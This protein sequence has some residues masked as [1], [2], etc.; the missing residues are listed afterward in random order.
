MLTCLPSLTTRI[1]RGVR[2]LPT[3]GH[4]LPNESHH[5]F[6]RAS[7]ADSRRPHSYTGSGHVVQSESV[8]PPAQPRCSERWWTTR[9]ATSR[10]SATVHPPTTATPAASTVWLPG[11]AT[12]GAAPSDSTTTA[13]AGW[14]RGTAAQFYA[15]TTT[16]AVPEFCRRSA[17]HASAASTGYTTSS[18][19]T[20]TSGGTAGAAQHGG[21][22]TAVAVRAARTLAAPGPF[23]ERD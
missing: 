21:G 15:A 16:D 18:T 7:L 5:R 9:T 17:I 1:V 10:W 4:P 8:L 14:R 19:T 13:A 20:T 12:A 22:R 11:P 3:C 2:G 6:G 23:S